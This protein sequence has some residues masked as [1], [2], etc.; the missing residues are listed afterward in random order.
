MKPPHVAESAFTMECEVL[1]WYDLIG[2]KGKP[3]QAVILGK[4]KRFQVASVLFFSPVKRYNANLG[5]NE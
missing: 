3:T 5:L 4:I 1:H 2:D